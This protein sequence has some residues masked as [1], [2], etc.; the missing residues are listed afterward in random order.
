MVLETQLQHCKDIY[1][2]RLLLK[3]E[4][5]ASQLWPWQTGTQ[6]YYGGSAIR[7]VHLMLILEER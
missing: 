7:T 3:E 1:F 5:Y 4:N 6:G 2:K